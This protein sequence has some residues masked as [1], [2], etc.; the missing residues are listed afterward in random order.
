MTHCTK[1]NKEALYSAR[2]HSFD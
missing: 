1:Q 2:A